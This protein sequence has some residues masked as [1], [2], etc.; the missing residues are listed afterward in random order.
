MPVAQRI[1]FHAQDDRQFILADD[2]AGFLRRVN[3]LHPA[4][5]GAARLLIHKCSHFLHRRHLDLDGM[6][7]IMGQ[8]GAGLDGQQLIV[9]RQ[10]GDQ[11]QSTLVGA[12]NPIDVG[13]LVHQGGKARPDDELGPAA[14]SRV[15]KLRV[16]I[17]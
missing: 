12:V 14:G 17:Q 8:I 16:H 10:A 15:A 11:A 7:I 6:F 2:L 5:S 9:D 3:N 13:L 4:F 1:D